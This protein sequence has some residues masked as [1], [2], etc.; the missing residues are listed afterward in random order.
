MRRALAALLLVLAW[1]AAAKST[2]GGRG[3]VDANHAAP[4]ATS[5]RS[6]SGQAGGMRQ[7]TPRGAV[8]PLDPSRR[9][10]EQDCTRPFDA[11]AGNL[12]CR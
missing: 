8:P 2:A 3:H 4:F 6:A 5:P 10:I 12:K 1:P 7:Q 9:V 11:S